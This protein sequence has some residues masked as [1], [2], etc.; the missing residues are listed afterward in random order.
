MQD[1]VDLAYSTGPTRREAYCDDDATP[2]WANLFVSTDDGV[3]AE[4]SLSSFLSLFMS[5][6]HLPVVTILAGAAKNRVCNS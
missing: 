4:T 6:S 5:I 3:G 1:Q 2:E